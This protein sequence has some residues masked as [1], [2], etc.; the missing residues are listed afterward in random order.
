M[1]VKAVDK[2]DGCFECAHTAREWNRGRAYCAHYGCIVYIS[3]ITGVYKRILRSG[4]GEG[5]KHISIG[6]C[7]KWRDQDGNAA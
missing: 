1:I 7:Q 3:E 4:E 2:K 5:E 6:T